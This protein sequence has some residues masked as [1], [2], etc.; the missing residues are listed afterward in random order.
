MTAISQG[1]TTITFGYDVGDR[2]TSAVLPG[3]ENA[4]YTWDAASQLSGITYTNGSTTLGT[5][6]YGYDLAGQIVL[7]GGSLFQSVL[8][9]SVT[10]ASYDLA[11]RL[12]SR[13]AA[14]VT[15]TPAFD[16]N[17]G[18]TS[19]GVRT[20]VWDSRNRLTNIAGVASFTY[21]SFN[22]RKSI[23]Q[24]GACLIGGD[25]HHAPEIIGN[26][27]RIDTAKR[28]L[29]AGKLQ[30][31]HHVRRF[32]EAETEEDAGD[33]RTDR[34]EL[35]ALGGFDPRLIDADGGDKQLCVPKTLSD[36]MM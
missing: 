4:T 13:T 19:D 14:G 29:E 22:R 3:G 16:A 25:H 9:A 30:P 6:T 34:H 5:L 32:H 15:S 35:D 28:G 12:S 18:L 8:P 20:F 24:N 2:R 26:A 31:L 23:T 27:F 10:S 11:N 1:G 17:G 21:D 7:R 36:L 33:A